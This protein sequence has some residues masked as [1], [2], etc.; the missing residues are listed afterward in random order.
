MA[1]TIDLQNDAGLADLPSQRRFGIWIE[2]ALQRSYERLEQTIRVVDEDES[3]ELNHRFRGRDSATNV[4]AFPGDAEHLDY[5]CLGDLVICAPL[6]A[7]EAAAQGKASEAH[8]AHLVVHGMLHLQGYDHRD[9][10][11]AGQM[12][13]LE[14]TILDSLGYANPYNE[15]VQSLQ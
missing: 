11:E 15:D 3:R 13:A 10:T 5:D 4:L 2:A 12:E 8:W 14:I 1:V 9:A 6:V 7:V